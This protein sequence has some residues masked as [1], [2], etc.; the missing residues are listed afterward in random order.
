M[1]RSTGVVRLDFDT[2]LQQDIAGVESFGHIHYGDAGL[3]IARRDCGLNWRCASP[4]RKKRSMQIQTGEAWNFEHSPRQNL[5][6]GSDDNQIRRKAADLFSGLWIFDSRGLK[7][8][9][10]RLARRKLGEGGRLLPTN[11]CLFYRRRF[12]ALLAPDGL[13]RL[14]DDRNDFVFGVQQCS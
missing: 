2:A 12:N 4:A 5:P 9:R 8:R 14:S 6:I 13:I 3:A 10:A 11:Y 1:Q 7:D